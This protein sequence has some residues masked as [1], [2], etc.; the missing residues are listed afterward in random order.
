[1]RIIKSLVVKRRSM[2]P[3][4]QK[5]I[6]NTIGVKRYSDPE[7]QRAPFIRRNR[8][9]DGGTSSDIYV[10]INKLSQK[11]AEE[12][13]TKAGQ[14]E[15]LNKLQML[16][17]TGDLNKVTQNLSD[18]Q[19]TNLEDLLKQSNA[20]SRNNLFGLQAIYESLQKLG[21]KQQPFDLS[22]SIEG[23]EGATSGPTIVEEEIPEEVPDF[24]EM[25]EKAKEKAAEEETKQKELGQI[26]EKDIPE[27]DRN[28][29]ENIMKQKMYKDGVTV[30]DV[31]KYIV[32]IRK[33]ETIKK[34]N[35]NKI[36]MVSK[37]FEVVGHKGDNI[38][39]QYGQLTKEGAFKPGQ[40]TVGTVNTYLKEKK[41]RYVYIINL[42]VKNDE[43]GNYTKRP[44]NKR[45][46]D[47]Y[48]I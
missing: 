46:L 12:S 5:V 15:V 45:L 30:L 9:S 29:I 43:I 11:V 38:V 48:S 26:E 6:Q 4:V 41:G 3:S 20:S 19:K 28:V 35:I 16:Q 17:K 36:F 32:S 33:G 44:G 2:Q 37:S 27:D 21:S 22:R 39:P 24:A 42:Y 7:V 23:P 13:K 25:I 18:T 31:Y 40:L 8:F 1:M 47:E 10:D 34:S 14:L